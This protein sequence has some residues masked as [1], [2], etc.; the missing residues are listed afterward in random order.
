VIRLDPGELVLMRFNGDVT[1]YVP[2][3]A[4]VGDDQRCSGYVEVLWLDV[5]RGCGGSVDVVDGEVRRGVRDPDRTQGDLLLW[6][7]TC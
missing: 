1:L 5:E 2:A 6:R 7:P 4:Y 3:G